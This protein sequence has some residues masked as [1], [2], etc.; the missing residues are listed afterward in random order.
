MTSRPSRF[1]FARRIGS[2]LIASV[3]LI[4][5]CES[6][7][8]TSAQVERMDAASAERAMIGT[9]SVRYVV[10]GKPVSE[11][12]AKAISAEHITSVAVTK[13]RD[14]LSEIRITT[15]DAPPVVKLASEPAP[16][17]RLFDGLLI[18]D[19]VVTES[20]AMNRLDHDRIA[21]IEV[22]KGAAAAKLYSDPRALNGVINVTMKPK[23]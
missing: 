11:A 10:D 12:V 3:A 15:K 8:P 2:G 13:P 21:S 5:A 9:G 20:A 19:G 16:R 4:T 18:I 22:I 17:P 7:L 6:Q 1:A 14:A 23:P